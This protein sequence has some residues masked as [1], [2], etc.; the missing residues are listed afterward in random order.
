MKK[1]ARTHDE[2]EALRIT[3]QTARI[4]AIAFDMESG[5]EKAA[6]FLRDFATET[7]KRLNKEDG[8]G[9]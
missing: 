8:N 1:A 9:R 6:K 7:D 2:R 5:H 3:A 4:V